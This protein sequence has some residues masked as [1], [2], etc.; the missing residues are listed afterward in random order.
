MVKTRLLNVVNARPTVGRVGNKFHVPLYPPTSVIRQI[1][2]TSL[3][4]LC[5]P[6]LYD[7]C[8]LEVEVHTFWTPQLDW[9]GDQ[10]R[11]FPLLFHENRLWHI[12]WEAGWT[13]R[14]HSEER[15]FA[16][17][18]GCRMPVVR[19]VSIHFIIFPH[20]VTTVYKVPHLVDYTSS[21]GEKAEDIQGKYVGALWT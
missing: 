10:L 11:V 20:C 1:L 17:R 9:G 8:G 5:A 13:Y 21:V 14:G 3:L 4:V 6:C 12:G 18:V 19:Y 7:C 15:I 2:C 16:P